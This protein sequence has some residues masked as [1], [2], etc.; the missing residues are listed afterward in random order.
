MSITG[1]DWDP[2]RSSPKRGKWCESST[3]GKGW[4]VLSPDFKEL[5]KH[6]ADAKARYLIVG[7]Y[8]VMLYTEPRFTK[9]L[10]LWVEATPENAQRVFNALTGFGAPLSGMK[11]A[12]FAN[13][14]FFYQLGRPP[15]RV[16]ILMSV[17]GVKFA[18][19]WP[20]R[21]EQSVDGIPAVFVGREELIR[22]KEACGRHI[23]LH[24]AE[25]LRKHKHP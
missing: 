17:S 20:N 12:D 4:E 19:A 14:G 6:L 5:L 7:G 11:P 3:P 9:D 21:V 22:M 15:I 13:E 23:D 2:K 10:D 1:S 18:D 16:D 24:D 25:Q 8:A